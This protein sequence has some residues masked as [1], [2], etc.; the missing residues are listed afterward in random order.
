MPLGKFRKRK[1]GKFLM[2][3]KS[4]VVYLALLCSSLS[5]ELGN[6][7][8]TFWLSFSMFSSNPKKAASV[9]LLAIVKGGRI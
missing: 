6:C 3:R 9:T 2:K 5:K 7:L 4:L 8:S 1:T